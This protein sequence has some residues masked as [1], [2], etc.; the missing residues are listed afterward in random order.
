MNRRGRAGS[1]T[2]RPASSLTVSGYVVAVGVAAWRGV[3]AGEA[4]D[5]GAAGVPPPEEVAG[6][7]PT[8]TGDALV[9]T[10]ARTVGGGV[11]PAGAVAG[12]PA[13]ATNRV[14]SRPSKR[15]IG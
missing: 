9:P 13:Q 7:P 3:P 2:S 6:A 8:A 4:A 1:V 14:V 12:T 5:P 11:P 15:V 10:A